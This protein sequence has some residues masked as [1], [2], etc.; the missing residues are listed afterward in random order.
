M[1]IRTSLFIILMALCSLKLRSQGEQPRSNKHVSDRTEAACLQEPPLI[2]A[3]NGVEVFEGGFSGMHYIP[4]TKLEFYLINDRGPNIPMPQNDSKTDA[5]IKVFPFPE[6]TQ[7]LVRVR[8]N[9]D[10]LEVLEVLELKDS[11]GNSLSGLPHLG[12][13]NELGEIAWKNTAGDVVHPH[14]SGVDIEGITFDSDSTFWFAEEYRP[15]LWHMHLKTGRALAVIEPGEG[16]ASGL[17][18]PEI[19]RKRAPN[20]GF[21]AIATGG[22]G[23]IHALLQSPLWNPDAKTGKFTQINRMVTF[24]PMS[25]KLTTRLYEMNAPRGKVSGHQWK[26][27]DMTA[28]DSHRFIVIEHGA[29]GGEFY[30]DLYLIDLR[31]ATVVEEHLEKHTPK[32]EIE[33]YMNASTLQRASQLRTVQKTHLLDL[34]KAGYPLTHGKPEGIALIDSSTVAIMNDN[35]YALDWSTE[36]ESVVQTSVQTCIRLFTISIPALE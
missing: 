26:I 23:R 31:G 24:D 10:N 11:Q 1:N 18:L 7:K 27:G 28:V 33:A 13:K 15:S 21:E 34:I 29:S 25:R 36:T 20:R 6:Y 8:M 35:D 17:S 32:H 30:A 5:E 2:G 16:S 3:F 14:P 12:A 19:F 22:D 4:G 9:S